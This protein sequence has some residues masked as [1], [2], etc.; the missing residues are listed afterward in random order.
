VIFQRPRNKTMWLARLTAAFFTLPIPL[1]LLWMSFHERGVDLA[2]AVSG[3]LSLDA[4]LQ[5]LRPSSDIFFNFWAAMLRGLAYSFAAGLIAA[6]I[7]ICFVGPLAFWSRSSASTLAYSLLGLTLLPQTFLVLAILQIASVAGLPTA[8]SGLIIAT[9]ALAL[10]PL[11]CW[12]SWLV[13]GTD[14]RGHLVNFAIDRAAAGTVVKVL[15]SKFGGQ[16]V[17]VF[18]VVFALALGNFIVPFSLGDNSTYTGL[19]LLLSFSSNLGRDWATIGAAGTMILLPVVIMS[20]V[21]GTF[22]ANIFEASASRE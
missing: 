19:V 21:V 8:N 11:A 17:H 7:A 13:V 16:I 18:I 15:L 20:V 14:L 5:F 2:A 9:L 3:S 12:I 10:A 4:Y 1:C 6:S 22:L